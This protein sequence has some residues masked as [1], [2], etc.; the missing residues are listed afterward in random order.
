MPSAKTLVLDGPFAKGR[1]NQE[2]ENQ[3]TR[4]IGRAVM[5]PVSGG[6][7][8]EVTWRMSFECCVVRGHVSYAP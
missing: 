1:K 4:V 6:V 3:Q 2:S 5:F 8:A 7:E